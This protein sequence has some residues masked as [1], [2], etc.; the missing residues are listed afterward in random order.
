MVWAKAKDLVGKVVAV[1]RV[2]KAE[3]VSPNPSFGLSDFSSR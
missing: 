3:T 2:V 1:V